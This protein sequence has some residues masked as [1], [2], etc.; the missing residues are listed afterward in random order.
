[1]DIDDV[2]EQHWKR[3]RDI[4]RRLKD[5]KATEDEQKDL[6]A[7]RRLH[8]AGFFDSIKNRMTDFFSY[9]KAFSN[10][11]TIF[12]NSVK[13]SKIAKLEVVR[14]PLGYMAQTFSDIATLGQFSQTAK[15]LGYDRVYHLYIQFTLEDGTQILYEKNETVVFRKASPPRGDKT[16]AM[17]VPVPPGMTIGQFVSTAQSKM[18]ADDYW[19]Y[20]ILK[21]LNC[22]K[23]VRDNLEANGLL[24]P[25]LEKFIMQDA[26]ALI[27]AAPTKLQDFTQ[28]AIDVGSFLRKLTGSGM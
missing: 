8:G 11:D 21:N 20:S 16:S 1:M 23:F 26:S 18:S 28:K 15:K 9:R 22:Q 19:H 6:I 4:E 3:Y 2:K 25:E 10:S 13:D 12:Y 24:T 17:V 7:Y 5:G 14:T 27:A